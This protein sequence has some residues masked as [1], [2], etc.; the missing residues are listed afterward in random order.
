MEED[1]DNSMHSYFNVVLQLG[2]VR[3]MVEN[4]TNLSACSSTV[5]KKVR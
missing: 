4:T 2:S 5:H 1:I 3:H